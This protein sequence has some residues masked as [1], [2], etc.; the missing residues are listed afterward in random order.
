M[1]S[2]FWWCRLQSEMHCIQN[3]GKTQKVRVSSS[4]WVAELTQILDPRFGNDLFDL[5]DILRRYVVLPSFNGVSKEDTSSGVILKDSSR[6]SFMHNLLHEDSLQDQFEDEIVAFLRETAIGDKWSNPF[7]WWCVNEKRYPH[8]APSLGKFSPFRLLLCGVITIFLLLVIS[9]T[10]TARDS[11]MIQYWQRY[12]SI[13]GAS[14][15]SRLSRQM[16]MALV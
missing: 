8:I 6:K 7:E 5:A 10:C 16:Y 2:N 1:K 9:S 12:L 13:H 4:Q 15:L 14:W 11:Q 3:E